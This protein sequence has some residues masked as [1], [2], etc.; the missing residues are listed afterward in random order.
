M[1]ILVSDQLAL[2]VGECLAPHDV[3]RLV[4]RLGHNVAVDRSADA[5]H[6]DSAL[7]GY[8]IALDSGSPEQ[9]RRHDRWILRLT[10][11]LGECVAER[12][13]IVGLTRED[14]QA[15]EPAVRAL[16]T[17]LARPRL[18]ISLQAGVTHGDGLHVGYSLWR[19]PS[20]RRAARHMVREMAYAGAPSASMGLGLQWDGC[21]GIFGG[22]RSV[23]LV[24][25]FGRQLV[26]TSDPRGWAAALAQGIIAYSHDLQAKPLLLSTTVDETA[27]PSAAPS[28]HA[29]SASLPI[30]PVPDVTARARAVEPQPEAA[31]GIGLASSLEAGQAPMETAAQAVARIM[32]AR[33]LPEGYRPLLTAT[34]RDPYPQTLSPQHAGNP[35]APAPGHPAQL[36]NAAPRVVRG[37]LAR[38]LPD[39]Y[40]PLTSGT[41][42]VAYA[43]GGSADIG[44]VPALTGSNPSNGGA[45]RP[46]RV[47]RSR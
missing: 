46:T 23:S 10:R 20:G 26:G 1:R 15:V 27:P 38:G 47:V 8:R 7:A 19:S 36:A 39:W 16:R 43:R 25:V 28:G 41:A 33:G 12:G 13:G 32:R 24:I 22:V 40:R 11:L 45:P 17:R 42:A 2:E 31:R 37:T 44:L 35:P 6:V 14:D 21:R 3:L 5:V 30:Q 18:T 9:N 34:P 29:S 4:R